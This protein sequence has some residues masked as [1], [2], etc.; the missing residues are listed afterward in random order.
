MD[1]VAK[2]AADFHRR[3]GFTDGTVSKECSVSS[4]LNSPT[5]FSRFSPA[6]GQGTETAWTSRNSVTVASMVFVFFV[7]QVIQA[8]CV[9]SSDTLTVIEV[10]E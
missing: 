6:M 8:F 9:G 10:L 1:F 3:N 7:N 2:F 5:T 4:K